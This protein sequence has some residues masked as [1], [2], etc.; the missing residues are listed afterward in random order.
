MDQAEELKRLKAELAALKASIGQKNSGPKQTESTPPS[1]NL[2]AAQPA[3]KSRPTV[4]LIGSKHAAPIT[5]AIPSHSTQSIQSPFTHGPGTSVRNSL[6]AP[7]AQNVG[8]PRHL[9]D[10]I[11]SRS[12]TDGG[13]VSGNMVA[14][15][16][17]SQRNKK[18]LLG[19][20]YT[21]PSSEKIARRAAVKI[22]PASTITP[23]PRNTGHTPLP[24][25]GS[26]KTKEEAAPLNHTEETA[27]RKQ[28]DV[29]QSEE[30]KHSGVAAEQAEEDVL[31]DVQ[32]NLE[33][34]TEKGHAQP[35]VDDMATNN[36]Q[37]DNHLQSDKDTVMKDYSPEGD[38]PA[39]EPADFFANSGRR[40][41][42]SSL[43]SG[44]DRKDIWDLIEKRAGLGN[45]IETIAIFRRP[46]GRPGYAFVDFADTKDAL[47]I[48][49][50]MDNEHL[51]GWPIN[52]RMARDLSKVNID[53]L[54]NDGSANP[55]LKNE[56]SKI[57]ED[58]RSST[59]CRYWLQGHCRNGVA[60]T[61]A[62]GSYVQRSFSASKLSRPQSVTRHQG[63]SGNKKPY[64]FSN[65]P[66]PADGDDEEV[67]ASIFGTSVYRPT[68][69]RI[70]TDDF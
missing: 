63:L 38:T 29:K 37:G 9:S 64:N 2:P 26:S 3:A 25:K 44:A 32:E 45:N 14:P 34:T 15:P 13:S 61:F 11:A 58:N 21:P 12:N 52:L 70:I 10:N 6:V 68:A 50:W 57:D 54:I 22:V 1:T 40:I 62:H 56:A 20:D 65:I 55:Q 60:C 42:I 43:P 7:S 23:T 36:K 17:T 48:V 51:F 46:D 18:S 59:S 5:P 27:Q 31:R 28:E 19:Q 35:D 66:L 69:L 16:A 53:D 39:A 47:H 67:G 41:C 8:Q 49:K 4:G 33:A 30:Q 24:K